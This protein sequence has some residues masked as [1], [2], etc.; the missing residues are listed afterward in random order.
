[1]NTQRNFWYAPLRLSIVVNKN[2]ATVEQQLTN[3]VCCALKSR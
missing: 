1:L 2:V 3:V